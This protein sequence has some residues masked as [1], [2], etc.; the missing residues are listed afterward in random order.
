M[1]VYHHNSSDAELLEAFVQGNEGAF[2]LF[3]QRHFLP[4]RRWLSLSLAEDADIEDVIQETF[5]VV[6]ESSNNFRGENARAWV[7]GIGRRKAFRLFRKRSGEP[8]YFEGLD[9]L[10]LKAGWGDPEFALGQAEDREV[11]RRNLRRLDPESRE[12]LVLRDIEEFS[13]METAEILGL[14]VPA[15]KSRLH[16]ARLKLLAQIRSEEGR[17]GT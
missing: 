2:V 9:E 17:N 13:T 8:E 11:V 12:I 5:Q 16:R 15:V 6:I 7:F 3:V 4:L 1:C 14:A 10:A